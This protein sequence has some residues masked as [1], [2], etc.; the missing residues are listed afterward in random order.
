[1][2]GPEIP[3]RCAARLPEFF[4][5]GLLCLQSG[6]EILRETSG[7]MCSVFN[8]TEQ[9]SICV[10]LES[11]SG[12]RNLIPDRLGANTLRSEYKHSEPLAVRPFFALG[13]GSNLE[14][15][16]QKERRNPQTYM[17]KYLSELAKFGDLARF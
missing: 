7:H 9:L 13:G 3:A 12:F 11:D 10:F 17:N 8:I 16:S 15:R 5:L 2:C 4:G 1:M 14:S 6:S